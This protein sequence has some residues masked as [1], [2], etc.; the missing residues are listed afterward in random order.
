MLIGVF[1]IPVQ[2]GYVWDYT[3]KV[4]G[5]QYMYDNGSIIVSGA[6]G[7]SSNAKIEFLK[8][9]GGKKVQWS[10]SPKGIITLNPKGKACKFSVQKEGTATVTAKV[11]KKKYRMKLTTEIIEPYLSDTSKTLEVGEKLNLWLCYGNAKGWSL[12][13][14]S[15]KIVSIKKVDKNEYRVTAKKKGTAVIFVRISKNKSLACTIHVKAKAK[16]ITKA[17]AD[18]SVSGAPAV[19][20]NMFNLLNQERIKAGVGRVKYDK[21]LASVAKIRA[22]EA[23]QKWSH[24][25]PNGNPWWWLLGDKGITYTS[26]VSEILSKDYDTAELSVYGWMHSSGHKKIVLGKKF[27]KMGVGYYTKNGKKYWCVIFDK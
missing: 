11:G 5:F 26:Q 22:K 17:Q 7:T 18:A 6:K 14:S 4:L 15:K 25:R 27:R 20:R 23:S 10:V 19:N 9:T 24:T 8:D 1:Q 21:N 12:S 13:K 3:F 2:A 16:P